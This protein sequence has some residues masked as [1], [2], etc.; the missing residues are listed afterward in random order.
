MDQLTHIAAII[1]LTMGAA[2]ASGI[3]LYAAIFMLG[4]MG[5]TEGAQLP[6]DL[7]ILSHPA[8][9]VAAG[10][11]YVV[12]FVADKVPGV[13]TGWDTL[14]TFI[15][16]PAGA[17]LAAGAV[18]TVEPALTLA[19]AL[20][21][22]S[23]AAASHAVK[24]GT[25][26]LINASPEPVSNWA[27]STAEDIGVVGGLWLA[28]YHPFLFLALFVAFIAF[29]I[30][31]LPRIWAGVKRIFRFLAGLFRTGNVPGGQGQ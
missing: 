26:V 10:F 18:G 17:V 29:V 28:V 15:R 11:M 1:A 25:R 20:V 7:E 2:W 24:S 12:E 27:A 23:V 6:P 16:I 4:I 22:G 3:N 19:A 30:W 14:H 8:V 9:L 31:L 21:G 13:D 5:M